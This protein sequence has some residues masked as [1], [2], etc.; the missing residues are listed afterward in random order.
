MHEIGHTAGLYHEH[1]RSD[2]DDF[3]RIFLR[4][5]R[6]GGEG[7]FDLVPGSLNSDR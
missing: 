3:V 2:R 5:V 6:P 4:N 7:N 1:Q